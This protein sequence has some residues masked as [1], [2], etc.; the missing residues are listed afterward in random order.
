MRHIA[1]GLIRPAA[2]IAFAVILFSCRQHPAEKEPAP[3]APS[4][5][6][7][8]ASPAQQNTGSILDSGLSE[9]CGKTQIAVRVPRELPE[10]LTGIRAVN[11]VASPDQ[12]QICDAA[13]KR[14]ALIAE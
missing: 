2:G 5:A 4:V 8:T 9:I 11:G 3:E 6:L 12:Y 14:C 7:S 10:A 13:D 1:A